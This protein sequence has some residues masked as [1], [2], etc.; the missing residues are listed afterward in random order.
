MLINA[1]KTHH[2]ILIVPPAAELMELKM[3]TS[4]MTLT[5]GTPLFLL[6]TSGSFHSFICSLGT[7]NGTCLLGLLGGV[8]E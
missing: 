6:R 3:C 7:V 4:C 8:S 1:N 2:I 5:K